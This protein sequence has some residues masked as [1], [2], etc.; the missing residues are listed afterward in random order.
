MGQPQGGFPKDIQAIVLKGKKPITGRPG[1]HLLAVDFGKI[2]EEMASFCPDP[3][4]KDLVSYCLYPKV[5][6]DYLAHTHEY[7]DL[8]ILDTSVFFNGL[9]PGRPLK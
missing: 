3:T 6:T 1:E 7:S 5:L 8:S 4:M 2:K 9:A